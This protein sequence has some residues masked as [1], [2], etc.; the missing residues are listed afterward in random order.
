MKSSK[1]GDTKRHWTAAEANFVRTNAQKMSLADMATR[2]SR[3]ELSVQLYML[4]HGIARRQTVK[5]NL[6]RELVGVKIATDY[7]HPT[8]EFYR[9]VD[10]NQVRFQQI[11][12]GYRQAT[13]DE[14]ERVAKH[15]N[16]TRDE[17]MQFMFNRQLDLFDDK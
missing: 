15:L 8:R 5:R 6:L 3:S 10:I 17:L 13:S 12:Q 2:L 16:F 11:W 9:A 1:M 7:F 14:M 4:R